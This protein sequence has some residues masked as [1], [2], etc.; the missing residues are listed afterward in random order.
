MRDT[1]IG[2]RTLLYFK[3]WT[4]DKHKEK[5]SGYSKMAEQV[6]EHLESALVN[7][8]RPRSLLDSSLPTESQISRMMQTNYEY[9]KELVTHYINLQTQYLNNFG[10]LSIKLKSESGEKS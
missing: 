10:D 8:N 7:R 2:L 9:D 4:E 5:A 3:S 1:N 6:M